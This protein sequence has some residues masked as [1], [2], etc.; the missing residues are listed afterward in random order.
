MWV[1]REFPLFMVTPTEIGED[2]GSAGK[3]QMKHQC[4]LFYQCLVSHCHGS[5]CTDTV[6]PMMCLGCSTYLH[7]SRSIMLPPQARSWCSEWSA[8][9]WSQTASSGGQAA[10][11]WVCMAVGVVSA[12]CKHVSVQAFADHACNKY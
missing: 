4:V 5:T 7:A 12:I 6:Q 11:G 1:F 2:K 3:S 8:G 9:C 10:G